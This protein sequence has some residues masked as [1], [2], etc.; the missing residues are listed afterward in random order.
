MMSVAYRRVRK[1]VC[2]PSWVSGI[3]PFLDSAHGVDPVRE[4]ILAYANSAWGARVVACLQALLHGDKGGI[5]SAATPEV[6][7]QRSERAYEERNPG[8]FAP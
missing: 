2:D 7:G 3:T 5:M 1:A 4:R 6:R 8:V